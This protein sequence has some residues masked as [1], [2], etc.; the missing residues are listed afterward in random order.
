MNI[1]QHERQEFQIVNA[2]W[3]FNRGREVDS[4]TTDSAG[5]GGYVKNLIQ[6][7][8]SWNRGVSEVRLIQLHNH[9][10]ITATAS[11]GYGQETLRPRVQLSQVVLPE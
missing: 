1:T 6:R 5:N 9:P 7:I 10:V 2:A 4:R 3:I 11:T 8:K